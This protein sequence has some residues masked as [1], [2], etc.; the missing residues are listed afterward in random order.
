MHKSKYFKL[1]FEAKKHNILLHKAQIVDGEIT[2]ISNNTLEVKLK[3]NIL[4]ICEGSEISDFSIKPLWN[5]F[6]K[7]Y[8]YKFLIIKTDDQKQRYY[9]SYKAV[10]PEEIRNKIRPVPTA[11]HFRSLYSDLVQQIASYQIDK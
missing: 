3:N 2:N 11:N 10:H 4:G 7:G 8:T 6:R 9:L 1:K 5:Y